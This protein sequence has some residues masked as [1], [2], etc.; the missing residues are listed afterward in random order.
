M[1]LWIS[2]ECLRDPKPIADFIEQSVQA[3]R[4]PASAF[5]GDKFTRTSY[6]RSENFYRDFPDEDTYTCRGPLFTPCYD[7]YEFSVQNTPMTTMVIVPAL[8]PQACPGCT[9]RVL[10]F[11]KRRSIRNCW[12]RGFTSSLAL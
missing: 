9:G 10:C 8:R 7:R 3:V 2:L 5:A 12:P 4:G 6:Y 11:V 1:S